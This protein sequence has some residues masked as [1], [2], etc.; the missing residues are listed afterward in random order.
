MEQWSAVV[1]LV[2]N[3]RFKT[4]SFIVKRMFYFDE[5]L[6]KLS[7]SRAFNINLFRSYLTALCKALILR[8]CL[9]IELDHG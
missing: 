6:T 7:D 9:K 1:R 8:G 5:A 2:V 4:Y 3:D